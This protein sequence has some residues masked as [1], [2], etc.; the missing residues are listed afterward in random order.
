MTVITPLSRE[1]VTSF[2]II[3]LNMKA[4]TTELHIA[5]MPSDS[6]PMHLEKRIIKLNNASL[7][8]DEL[9]M[10]IVANMANMANMNGVVIYIRIF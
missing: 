5:K 3:D 9:H 1:N 10:L 4:I 2:H 6:M 8:D 7:N